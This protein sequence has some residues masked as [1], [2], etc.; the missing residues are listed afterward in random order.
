MPDLLGP[1]MVIVRT[2]DNNDKH[3]NSDEHDNHDNNDNIGLHVYHIY[4]RISVL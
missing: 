1:A 2:Y 4:M 3:D